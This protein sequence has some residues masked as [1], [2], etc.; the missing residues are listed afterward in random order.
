VRAQIRLGRAFGIPIGLHYTWIVLAAL[1]TVSLGGYFGFRHPDWSGGLVWGTAIV[2][3]VLFFATLILH[4]M[5]HALVARAHGIPVGSITLFA[6]GGVAQIE[7]DATRPGA[8]FFMA[9]VGPLTSAVIGFALIGLAMLGGW[10]PGAEPR[11]A[12][13]S[14][15]LWLGYINIVLALFN[16]IPGYPLDGGRVLRS[17]IWAITGSVD[18][19]TR[20]AARTGQA[21]AVVLIAYGL[22]RFF[23]QS[24]VGGLWV[25]LIGW[26]LFSAANSSYLQ[27]R[28]SARLRGVHVRDVMSG[29]CVPVEADMSV[30]AFVDSYLQRG[31]QGC[32]VV[33]DRGDG[34][35]P[36]GLVVPG[37]MRR[38]DRARWPVTPIRDAMRP[39]GSLQ[40]V[41]PEDPLLQ[42]LTMM[43]RT[44]VNQVPV[45]DHGHFE[46]VVTRSDVVNYV[47]ARSELGG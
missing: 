14:V 32:Y 38:I 13:V 18:R 35:E 24:D 12:P 46:G 33:S 10:V 40:A 15:A 47:H 5:S 3:G 31:G 1:I 17:I 9:I 36:V 44:D 43:G 22:V 21:V 25:A 7:E 37:D 45:M 39:F 6:L 26:F 42:V 30:Q 8:E 41:D 28:L 11:T 27:I 29:R 16:M 2:T 20:A 34:A 23:L 19:A 4:E